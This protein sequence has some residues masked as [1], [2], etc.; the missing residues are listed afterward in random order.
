MNP[1][2]SVP[3]DR[4]RDTAA[5]ILEEQALCGPCFLMATRRMHMIPSIGAEPI[6]SDVSER[7][8]TLITEA[9]VLLQRRPGEEI[10]LRPRRKAASRA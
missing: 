9:L 8:M 6:V 5:A 2:V 1:P 4:C 3:C 7:A 10:A